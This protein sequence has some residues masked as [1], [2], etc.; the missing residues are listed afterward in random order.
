[1]GWSLE[2]AKEGGEAIIHQREN[3]KLRS[4]SQS[5]QVRWNWLHLERKSLGS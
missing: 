2:R 4:I 1:M 5:S 3:E